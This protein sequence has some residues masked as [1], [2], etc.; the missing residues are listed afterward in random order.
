MASNDQEQAISPET[1]N[2]CI[3]FAKEDRWEEAINLFEND[4][5]CEHLY[6]KSLLTA[7]HFDKY[8]KEVPYFS[9]LQALGAINKAIE[10]KADPRYYYLKSVIC[11]S[12]SKLSPDSGGLAERLLESLNISPDTP[13][14]PYHNTDS[15]YNHIQPRNTCSAAS[16]YDSAANGSDAIIHT[17]STSTIPKEDWHQQA[18]DSI[19]IALQL[20]E[21]NVEYSLMKAKILL[22]NGQLESARQLL[23]I[24]MSNNP[25]R[26]DIILDLIDVL[27]KMDMGEEAISTISEALQNKPSDMILVEKKLKLLIKHE[28]NDELDA[29]RNILIQNTDLSFDVYLALITASTALHDIPSAINILN[30]AVSV[31]FVPEMYFSQVARECADNNL[32]TEAKNVIPLAKSNYYR[33]DYDQDY[34][35]DSLEELYYIIYDYLIREKEYQEALNVAEMASTDGLVRFDAERIRPLVYL[36]RLNDAITIIQQPDI[37]DI[38]GIIADIWESA[39]YNEVYQLCEE[40]CDQ[41]GYLYDW[42]SFWSCVALGLDKKASEYLSRLSFKGLFEQLSNPERKENNIHIKELLQLELPFH[43]M[44]KE[45]FL[46]MLSMLFDGYK[47]FSDIERDYFS[48]QNSASTKESNC[49]PVLKNDASYIDLKSRIALLKMYMHESVELPSDF[50][51]FVFE[52]LFAAYDSIQ[53]VINWRIEEVRTHE[54]NRILSNLSHSIKNILRSIIDPLLNLKDELPGKAIIIGNALKGA[55]LIREMV[56]SINLSYET[57]VDDLLWDIKHPGT[58][59]MALQDMIISSLQYSIGNMFDSRY[60][61]TFA[62]NYYRS[63]KKQDFEVVK[64]EWKTVT[65][66]TS[67]GVLQIFANKN[68]FKLTVNLTD[69]A[70]YHIGNEKSSAIK[71]LILFQEIIF[72]AVKYASYVPRAERFIE[73]DLSEHDDILKLQISNSFRPEVQAKTTGVGKLVIENFAKVLDCAPVIITDNNVYSITMEFNNIWRDN[74]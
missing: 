31:D 18:M 28:R 59:N 58:E 8:Q 72:N 11:Y 13:A 14:L 41:T 37:F 22:S 44:H 23:E 54:R 60:F 12:H 52:L 1:M 53:L 16:L 45:L 21:S 47:K 19:E 33:Y 71:L 34:A 42:Y 62:A 64:E 46:T 27:E 4:Q 6:Y 32:Y 29:Y 67:L 43:K 7:M 63:L 2:K 26:N 9:R 36:G 40:I 68:M 73:I 39:L 38:E 30:T 25:D 70:Q 65:T 49:D 20:D 57:S 50:L 48:Q 35:N 5:N 74:A 3:E 69:S 51:H 17:K 55:N 24:T 66:T 10:M 56:N 15:Y 61:P